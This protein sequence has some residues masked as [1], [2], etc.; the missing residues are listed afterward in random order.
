MTGCCGQPGA[1]PILSLYLTENFG[2]LVTPLGLVLMAYLPLAVSI[3]AVVIAKAE[4]KNISG[5]F[6]GIAKSPTIYGASTGMLAGCPTCAASLLLVLAGGT[7]ILGVTT[8]LLA[9]YQPAIV[10]ASFGLLLMAP[11]IAALRS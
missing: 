10:L 4:I 7:S 2:L 6:C 1:F 8:S 9:N 3:N 11:I 5:V